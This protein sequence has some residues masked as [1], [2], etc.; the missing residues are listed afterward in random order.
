[1][2]AYTAYFDTGG[3]PADRKTLFVSGFVSTEKKW[4][5]FD[6][7]WTRLL[8][9]EGVRCPFHMT[10]FVLGRGAFGRWKDDNA[11]RVATVKRLTHVIK[12][13]VHK[14]VSTGVTIA[15]FRRVE[16]DFDFAA[17]HL[18]PYSLC[19]TESIVRVERW[20]MFYTPRKNARIA[21]VLEAGDYDQHTLQLRLQAIDP[22]GPTVQFRQKSGPGDDPYG[23]TPFQPCDLVAWLHASSSHSVLDG[24]LP[25]LLESFRD[26]QA[27]L[28]RDWGHF[29][30]ERLRGF[31]ETKGIPRRAR[32]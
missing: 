18:T 1:M 7:A 12:T 16:K 17:A 6:Q 23:F 21:F 22:E 24:S 11:R 28:P 9:G 10:H 26:V 30:E 20:R 5:A 14:S 8:K 25:R 2:A 32:G 15:D 13:H 4:R 31:C 19:A 27:Q 3:H 29:D